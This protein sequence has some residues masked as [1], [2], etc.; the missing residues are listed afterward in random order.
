MTVIAFDGITMAAD[1]HMTDGDRSCTIT[2]IWKHGDVVLAMC[3]DISYGLA[4][5]E[6]FLDG[7]DPDEFPE[8][9][10]RDTLSNLI[11]WDGKQIY[12]YERT[13]HPIY[14][15]DKFAA[16]GSGAMVAIGA[17]ACGALAVDA[18]RI[19]NRHCPTCG[20]GIEAFTLDRKTKRGK[21]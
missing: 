21:K 7:A 10:D 20:M 14:Y 17:M 16:W 11:V 8:P 5:K 19:A 9:Y 15:E 6:W 13:P 4:L 18:V 3:G 2:K 12:A 1:K